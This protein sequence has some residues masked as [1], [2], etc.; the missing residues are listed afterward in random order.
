[1]IT[2]RPAAARGHFDH[3]WLNTWHSF[4]FADYFD[5]NEMGFSVLRVINDDIIAPHSG[6]GRHG[7]RDMEIITY[8]LTGELAHGD[9]LENAAVLRPP[10]VQ[11]M[12]AGRGIRHS[13]ANPS[14]QA[15]HL[16]QI[17]IEPSVRGIE[18]EYEE[19][20]FHDAAKQNRWCLLASPDGAAGSMRI[21]Q[22]ARLM[23]TILAAGA[24]LTYALNSGRRAYAHVARGGIVTLNGQPLAAGDGAKIADE[25]A[26]SFVATGET[27]ILLFD[28]P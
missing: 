3:G 2:L 20:E 18:P 1:M 11:R 23:V 17:W 7:H 13:E 28:L 21:H 15:T 4:S 19:R 10:R 8:L 26:L 12:S 6:F 24:Q 5:P 14:T 9:S 27:E 22:D 16:L 25:T